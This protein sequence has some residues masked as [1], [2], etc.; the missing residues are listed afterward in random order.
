MPR[1]VIIGP[2][3]GHDILDFCA[4]ELVTFS[5]GHRVRPWQPWMSAC[6]RFLSIRQALENSNFDCQSHIMNGFQ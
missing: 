3:V 4:R 2:A 1:G 6:I 5:K